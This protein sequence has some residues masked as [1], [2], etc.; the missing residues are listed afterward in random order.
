MIVLY[1]KHFAYILYY[2]QIK[3]HKHFWFF[4]DTI[5]IFIFIYSIISL[6]GEIQEQREGILCIL[7]IKNVNLSSF[8]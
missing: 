8:C 4:L 2:I 6:I 5:F 1:A 7:K 3:I